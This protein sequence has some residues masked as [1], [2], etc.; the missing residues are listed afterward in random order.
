[1]ETQDYYVMSLVKFL[2]TAH[3]LEKERF[4]EK[5]FRDHWQIFYPKYFKHAKNFILHNEDGNIKFIEA[6]DFFI[7]T[8]ME[9]IEKL[10]KIL[11]EDIAIY[12]NLGRNTSH[13]MKTELMSDIRSQNIEIMCRRNYMEKLATAEF[14]SRTYK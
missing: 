7:D 1:M 11:D 5:Y 6:K 12:E 3:E 13:T 10:K 2:T 14:R 4:E 9:E 8:F